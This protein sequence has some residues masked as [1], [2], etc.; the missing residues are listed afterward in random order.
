MDFLP[1]SENTRDDREKEK[2][3]IEPVKGGGGGGVIPIH[4]ILKSQ[5]TVLGFSDDRLRGSLL[6]GQELAA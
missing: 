3:G 4:L 2:T 5:T 1:W 6:E